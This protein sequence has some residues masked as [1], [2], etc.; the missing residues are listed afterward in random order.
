MADDD[1]DFVT[2][3]TD[4]DL[5]E[6]L[7]CLGAGETLKV[8]ING[9]VQKT[10]M[11]APESTTGDGEPVMG[12]RENAC[13]VCS[14]EGHWTND[15]PFVVMGP[16]RDGADAS[17]ATT[18]TPTP[19]PSRFPQRWGEP[20]RMQTKDL[21]PLPGGYG[22]GSGT[23]SSWIA[24]NLA[25]DDVTAESLGAGGFPAPTPPPCWSDPDHHRP[26]AT[27]ADS[28]ALTSVP[29]GVHHGM[30]AAAAAVEQRSVV[31]PAA[32][33]TEPVVMCTLSTAALERIEPEQPEQSMQ[34]QGLAQPLVVLSAFYGEGKPQGRFDQGGLGI[35]TDV[36]G[37][38]EPV[39]KDG[40]LSVAAANAVFGDPLCGVRKQLTVTYR[41]MG[42]PV[43][44]KTVWEGQQLEI[45]AAADP[46][47]SPTPTLPVAAAAATPG[48]PPPPLQG[49]VRVGS[50]HCR[51]G[52]KMVQ[53]PALGLEVSATPT[54]TQQPGWTD[55]F[56][57]EVTGD[58]LKV[59]RTDV[60]N[61]GGWGQQLELSYKA[62][63]AA[64]VT[65]PAPDE[66]PGVITCTLNTAALQ[67]IEREAA[68]A[69]AAAAAAE[70]EHELKP[71][72][73]AA[74]VPEPV[75][76]V[77]LY[78]EQL[79][80]LAELGLAGGNE[81]FLVQMLGHADGSVADVV[82]TLLG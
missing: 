63:A 51:R 77:Q 70:H 41:V 75:P 10:A 55:A 36:L 20:P 17:S 8:Y 82:A 69:A 56:R 47:P 5:T 27:P 50:W 80:T 9:A 58:V 21:R 26:A 71:V 35:G 12:R 28:S 76:E 34:G 48:C 4:T 2:I 19:T 73:A 22:M 59:F 33:S 43:Q 24:Q 64:A 14:K 31:R 44:V 78:A 52:P 46:K 79:A 7:N 11:A 67:R 81:E 68:A 40:A 30:E 45:H 25:T 49:A 23:L 32:A 1:G 53:L 39:V 29:K 18:A 6:A 62:A 61:Q 38:V 37:K 60:N 54:N 3:G 13:S 16:Q 57:V 74:V 15:C 72:D 42:G 66:Q 65:E